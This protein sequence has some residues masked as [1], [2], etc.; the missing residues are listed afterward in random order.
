MLELKALLLTQG[1]HGMVS[2]AEGLAK[3]LK[4][5]FKHQNIKFIDIDNLDFRE[6]INSLEISIN[7]VGEQFGKLD[8]RKK[9]KLILLGNG[10]KVFNF[11]SIDLQ[12]YLP[13]GDEIDIYKDEDFNIYDCGN[14]INSGSNPNE[15]ILVPKKMSKM[16]FFEKLFHFLR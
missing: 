12:K 10:S 6:Y 13:V 14:F 15:V 9:I 11:N 3:A 2:Q 5:N 8:F 1:M 16:G 4:L 7:K